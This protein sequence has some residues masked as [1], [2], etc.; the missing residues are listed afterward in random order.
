MNLL[1]HYIVDVPYFSIDI[2]LPLI[3]L[4]EGNSLHGG[5]SQKISENAAQISDIAKKTMLNRVNTKKKP[6]R[7]II[8]HHKNRYLNLYFNMDFKDHRSR[9]HSTKQHRS[10]W[11]GKNY[12]ATVKSLPPQNNITLSTRKP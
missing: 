3:S 4:Q 9:K 11:G 7:T 12:T 1:P 10:K 8:T 5:F 2:G 6:Y